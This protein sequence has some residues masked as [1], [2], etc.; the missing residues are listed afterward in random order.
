MFFFFLLLLYKKSRCYNRI[1][2]EFDL[3]EIWNF[4]TSFDDFS[5]SA[6]DVIRVFV[7]AFNVLSHTHIETK[8]YIRMQLSYKHF[9]MRLHGEC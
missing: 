6:V 7:T 3:N 4:V 1:G 8:T 5:V 9:F 2:I